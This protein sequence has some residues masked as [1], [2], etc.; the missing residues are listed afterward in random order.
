MKVD[1]ACGCA[2]S[3]DTVVERPRYF[4]RQLITPDDLTLEQDYF[5][6]RLRRHNRLLHGWGVVCG[7]LVCPLPSGEPW[8]VIV[9]AGYILGPCGDEIVIER[10]QC[11]DLRT[12]CV[13][14]APAD[15]CETVDPWCSDVYVE[16]TPDEPLYVAVRYRETRRRPVRTQPVGCGCDETQCEYSRWHD[17]Y[18]ICILDHCPDS[19]AEP[20]AFDDAR[21]GHVPRCWECPPEPWVVLAKVEASEEGRVRTIDNCVCRRLVLSHAGFWWKCDA[22][23]PVVTGVENADAPLAPGET[24]EIAV[25]GTG[26]AAAAAVSL[27]GGVAATVAWESA[28]RLRVTVTVAAGA[29]DGPRTLVLRN[30]DCATATFANAIRVGTP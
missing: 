29:A 2:P 8:K 21:R 9:K 23:V 15:G 20:P 3:A 22:T 13:P 24:R 6:D 30:P 18:E 28:E 17:G 26:F 12:R 1:S 7:A 19:H 14:G 16:R 11:V 5:R 10:D 4:P 27:G 25:V